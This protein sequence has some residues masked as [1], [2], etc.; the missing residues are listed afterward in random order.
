MLFLINLNDDSFETIRLTRMDMTFVYSDGN[1]DW[2]KI[3]KFVSTWGMF[4]HTHKPLSTGPMCIFQLLE[5]VSVAC[6]GIRYATLLPFVIVPR[7]FCN[8]K[9]YVEC[10]LHMLHCIV[11]TQSL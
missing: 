2:K 5:P 3:I 8:D 10:P 9:I 4:H 6:N 7:I 11:S 1:C